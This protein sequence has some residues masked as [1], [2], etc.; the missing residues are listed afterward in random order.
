MNWPDRIATLS[1]N[2]DM[3]DRA[4]VAHLAADLMQARRM[5]SEWL[6]DGSISYAEVA[7]FLEYNKEEEGKR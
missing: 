4:D 6:Y 7:A 5:L 1:V 2:P 3:A